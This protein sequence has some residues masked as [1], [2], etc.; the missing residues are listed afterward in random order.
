MVIRQV[1]A[2]RDE[3]VAAKEKLIS[4]ISRWMGVFGED[5][6]IENLVRVTSIS[7][8]TG[9]IAGVDIPVFEGIEFEDIRYDLFETPPWV[10]P[11][12]Q[13]LKDIMALDAETKILEEQARLLADELRITTQRVNLFE[14]VKIPETKE[15]IRIIKS[16]SA[17]NRLPLSYEEKWQKGKP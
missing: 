13:F 6:G 2:E 4:D 5:V 8:S 16:I 14:K 1:E 17:T 12:V 9:N 3:K 15:S 7:T 10:D 11:G